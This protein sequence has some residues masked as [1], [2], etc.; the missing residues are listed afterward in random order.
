MAKSNIQVV[1][2][3]CHRDTPCQRCGKPATVTVVDQSEDL[4]GYEVYPYCCTPF[5]LC[6]DCLPDDSPDPLLDVLAKA[7]KQTLDQGP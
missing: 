6:N 7:V 5:D 1:G 4:Q 3:L 2:W